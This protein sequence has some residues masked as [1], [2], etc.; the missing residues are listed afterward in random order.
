M[1][2]IVPLSALLVLCVA[3]HC[4]AQGSPAVERPISVN[5]VFPNLTVFA[6]GAGSDSEAGIGALVPWADKLW[7]VGYVAHVRGEGLGL[8]EISEDMTMKKHPASVTGTFTNRM[9]HWPS[10]QAFIGPHAID[11]KGNVRTIE[12]LTKFRVTSTMTHLTVED[13]GWKNFVVE[14]DILGDGTWREYAKMAVRPPSRYAH[15][16]FPDGFSAHWVRI[17]AV[18]DCTATAYFFYN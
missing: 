2:K 3:V 8:Y 5:G 4:A 10:K 1:K 18:E 16:E 14:V 13:D 6:P 9:V 12:A 11:E 7:A 17:T 15:H